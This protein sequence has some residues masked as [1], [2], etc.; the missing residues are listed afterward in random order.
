MIESLEVKQIKNELATTVK[1]IT[2]VFKVKKPTLK[3]LEILTSQGHVI[4]YLNKWIIDTL[5]FFNIGKSM[6]EHQVMETSFLIWQT[7]PAMGIQE[8][9]FVFNQA[10]KGKYGK[11][12]DR[13]DGS[14]IF[15]WF[16]SFWEERLNA[17]EGL[18]H[19]D[20]IRNKERTGESYSTNQ[21]A[22]EYAY[23]VRKFAEKY[24]V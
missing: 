17:A 21:A 6:D 22:K 5:G 12:Y 18:S 11:I 9:Y 1:T 15:E 3:Q 16:N 19:Q 7:Y 24:K 23:K 20:H 10:K 2:D 14:I 13:I 8:I 4:A